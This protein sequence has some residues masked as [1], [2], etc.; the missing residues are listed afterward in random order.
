MIRIR[1]DLIK[2]LL[3]LIKTLLRLTF[4][5]CFDEGATDGFGK[6]TRA[7]TFF[8]IER[9]SP[10]IK[11]F[12]LPRNVAHAI[13]WSRVNASAA[14]MTKRFEP[15]GVPEV[16]VTRIVEFSADGDEVG[17][18]GV[19]EVGDEGVDEVGDEGV[20]EVGDEGVDEVGDEG[21]DEDGDGVDGAAQTAVF[22]S[23]PS[24]HDMV[25]VRV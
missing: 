18:E 3:S 25:P 1:L 15:V 19:D 11:T 4:G 10:G 12:S 9:N 22:A 23:V 21:V 13:S 20:D 24:V 16:S 17:D 8:F 2:T 6:R 14:L 7:H 5:I